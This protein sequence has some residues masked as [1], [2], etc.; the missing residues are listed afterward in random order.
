MGIKGIGLYEK[1]GENFVHIDTRTYKAFWYGHEQSPRSTFGGGAPMVSSPANTNPI[2]SLRYGSN[3]AEV[4]ELQED[5][6]ALGYDLGKWGA[7]G[8]YGNATVNAVKKF[9]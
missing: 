5:L 4:K 2:T 7:D 8:D 3:G 1:N 9:Q 6:I